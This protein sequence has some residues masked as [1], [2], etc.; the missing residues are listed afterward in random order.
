MDA[1]GEDSSLESD[2]DEELPQAAAAAATAAGA[3]LIIPAATT[4]TSSA[5]VA[6][7]PLEPQPL[8]PWQQLGEVAAPA[9]EG[10]VARVKMHERPDEPLAAPST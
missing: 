4:A 8:L 1:T 2:R 9:G 7:Q 6:A 10:R 5:A 3:P